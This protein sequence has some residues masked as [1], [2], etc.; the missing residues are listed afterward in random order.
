MYDNS[1][2]VD[3]RTTALN[4]TA[5]YDIANGM[6]V[7]DAAGEKVGSVAQ[8]DPAAGYM[9]VEKGWLFHKDIYIP[10]N[11]IT[12]ADENGIYLT[13]YKA[14]L[15]ADRYANPPVAGTTDI[16][17][18]GAEAPRTDEAFI[19][20]GG[21]TYVT[22]QATTDTIAADTTGTGSMATGA[23]ASERM[24]TGED[25]RVPVREEELVA[26]KERTAAGSV[27][28]HK[29]VIEEPRTVEVPLRHEEVTVER[30]PLTGDALNTED[31]FKEVD[32][33]VP[34]EDEQVVVGKRVT[35]EEVR[36]HKNVIEETK[37]VS[38]TVRKERVAVDDDT[39]T[40]RT[41]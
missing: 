1:E 8:Y 27:H 20:T 9:L 25:I 38:D 36:V 10:T 23:R 39:Q 21:S 2:S 7:F 26:G 6:D 15:N 32:I 22:D 29:D 33:D 24:A 3:P 30:V 18:V 40:R 11:E 4:T 14:D 37:Q 17:Y 19:N 31:A 5:R 41:P 35:G 34:V 13:T 12:S 16:G 28:I